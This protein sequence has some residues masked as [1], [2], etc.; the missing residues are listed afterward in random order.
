M[1]Q[2]SK[3]RTKNELI[4]ENFR[5]ILP[6]LKKMEQ[7]IY[8]FTAD[9]FMDLIV[10]IIK[11]ENQTTRFSLAHFFEA[12]NGITMNPDPLM[13][14]EMNHKEQIITPLS[15]R[16]VFGY[17]QT[18]NGNSSTNTGTYLEL[19]EFT[20][21]WSLNLLYQGHKLS[22]QKFLWK[23][24]PEE[25]PNQDYF[26]NGRGYVTHGVQQLLSPQEILFIMLEVQGFVSIQKGVDYLQVFQNQET[27]DKIFCIDELSK[28]MIE[29]GNYSKDDIKNYHYWTMLLPEER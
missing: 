28:S 29:S 13:D 11:Q 6:N 25:V 8:V 9:G 26:F 24:Q 22:E 5:H 21:Q 17:Q 18:Q 23:R 4:L 2:K 15:Y 12:T 14:F 20:L 16:D 19:L 3:M 27:G 10:H 7:G 1:T